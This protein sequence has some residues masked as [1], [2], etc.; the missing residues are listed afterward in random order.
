MILRKLPFASIGKFSAGHHHSSD[1]TSHPTRNPPSPLLA[2]GLEA[3]GAAVAGDTAQGGWTS[4]AANLAWPD[5][6]L[7]PGPSGAETGSP[8]PGLEHSHRWGCRPGSGNVSGPGPA[9]RWFPDSRD[10]RPGAR[11]LPAQGRDSGSHRDLDRL[12]GR[13][14]TQGANRR[15]VGGAGRPPHP[16]CLGQAPRAHRDREQDRD[17]EE[18]RIREGDRARRSRRPPHNP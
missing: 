4:G 16:G 5:R 10:V 3:G 2:Q 8:N 15:L 13:S 9:L 7:A 1:R 18:D 11:R 14:E 6:A 17:R 12:P